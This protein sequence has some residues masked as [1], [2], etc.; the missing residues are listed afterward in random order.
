ENI[1][2]EFVGPTG[3]KVATPRAIAKAAMCCLA[4]AWPQA[5]AFADLCR[6]ARHR[7]SGASVDA[8]LADQDAIALRTAFLASYANDPRGMIELRP[9]A[10]KLVNQLGA[11]PTASALAR[12]QATLGDASY[13][14]N[15]RHESV[16]VP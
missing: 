4:E 11:R 2:M 15:Q 7:L 9:R 12:W 5:L 3:E 8:A 6:Q 10:L 14:V 16:P 13:I 1:P